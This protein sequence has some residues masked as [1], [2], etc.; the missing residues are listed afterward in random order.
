MCYLKIKRS[1]H[2]DYDFAWDIEHFFDLMD[3]K[4]GWIYNRLNIHTDE[5]FKSLFLIV[6]I[7]IFN[8]GKTFVVNMITGQDYDS[9]VELHTKGLS[10]ILDLHL[11]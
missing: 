10:L 9:G 3:S 4:K 8:K 1:F 6:L 5:E 7:G 2:R 11:I